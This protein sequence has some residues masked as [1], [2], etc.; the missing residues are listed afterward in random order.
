MQIE[1]RIQQQQAQPVAGGRWPG[2]VKW[3]WRRKAEGP[4]RSRS[5]FAV[6]VLLLR[7]APHPPAGPSN[8]QFLLFTQV[9]VIPSRALTRSGSI[10]LVFSASQHLDSQA[11]VTRIICLVL[12]RTVSRLSYFL[13]FSLK[14]SNHWSLLLWT[15]CLL[16]LLF[17]PS[18]TRDSRNKRL[19]STLVS[20]ALSSSI[21]LAV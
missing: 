9:R 13:T 19:R 17:F 15:F 7:C 14:G 5:P 2:W 20:A 18:R 21:C 4:W 6:A 11:P 12:S 3:R 16:V 10:R 8:I 1:Y